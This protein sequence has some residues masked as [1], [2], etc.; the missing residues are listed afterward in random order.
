MATTALHPMVLTEELQ[1]LSRPRVGIFLQ[2]VSIDGEGLDLGVNFFGGVDV[3]V[4]RKD[5]AIP[6]G[7]IR[8]LAADD[9]DRLARLGRATIFAASHTRR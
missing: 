9:R 4:G 6:K 3:V 1:T 5:V 8:N 2:L 7:G